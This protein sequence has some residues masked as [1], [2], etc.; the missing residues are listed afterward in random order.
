MTTLYLSDDAP[1]M[2]Y[3]HIVDSVLQDLRKKLR[4]ELSQISEIEWNTDLNKPT[5]KNKNDQTTVIDLK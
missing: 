1:T 5:K 4:T 2:D 3:S